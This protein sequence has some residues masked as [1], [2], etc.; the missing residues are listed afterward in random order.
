MKRVLLVLLILAIL[1]GCFF[2]G[3]TETLYHEA[4]FLEM[5]NL[6]SLQRMDAAEADQLVKPLQVMRKITSLGLKE[7]SFI[8]PQ[9][10]L[11]DLDRSFTPIADKKWS[12]ETFT[13]TTGEELNAF[14]QQHPGKKIMVASNAIEIKESIVIPN[15]T[16][17]CATQTHLT[18]GGAFAAFMVEKA[19]IVGITGFVMDGGFDYGVY[20]QDSSDITV[21]DCR[22]LNLSRKPLVVVG[23]CSDIYVLRN[24]AEGNANGGLYFNGS[25]QKALIEDNDIID[26]KG[27]SNWMAGIVLTAID[28]AADR[29][30]Y[31]PFDEALHFPKE[32]RLD[33]MLSAPHDIVIRGNHVEE[34]NSSGIY[35][36]GPYNVYVVENHII[37]NDKEG[38]CLDYGTIGTFVT[39][40]D[41]MKNGNRARQT[42]EDLK[43]DFVFDHGR[44]AD[45]T[46]KSKLPGVSIDNAAYNIVYDNRISENYGSGVKMVRAGVRN[47]ISTNVLIGNN[48]GEN[49][50]FHFFGV[51]IGNAAADI[52]ATNIDFTPG[53]ENIICR[54]L[55]TGKHYTGIFIDTDTFINDFFDNTIM[56]ATHW[57]IECIS[58][59]FNSCVNNFSLVQSRGIPLSNT[60]AVAVGG[61]V[62]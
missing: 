44:M 49:D 32:Q 39:R 22:F 27:T 47:I 56:D 19:S 62:K 13:G 51:E 41:I 36:D 9:T 8:Y 37:G 53:Y 57:S 1:A 6:P 42:D 43:M 35:C 54:N 58:D 46:A 61:W 59:K 20:V 30:I 38:M 16:W 7:D 2:L 11:D 28:V 31:A 48:V 17:L 55:I 29:D 52:D 25:I 4:S 40:N 5:Q 24:R 26:N 14:L 3:S 10:S 12:E 33:T 34:N 50:L 21:S 23:D 60:I 15:K 18:G 45:G